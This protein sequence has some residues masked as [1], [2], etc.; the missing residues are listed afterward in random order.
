MA[1]VEKTASHVKTDEAGAAGDEYLHCSRDLGERGLT[2][3]ANLVNA[4][5]GRGKKYLAQM[6]RDYHVEGRAL[7]GD[8]NLVI[9]VVNVNL[10]I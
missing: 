9:E 2:S 1:F 7:Q 8:I 5:S 4:L 3:R 6:P 10:G